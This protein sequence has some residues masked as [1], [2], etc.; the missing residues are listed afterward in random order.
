MY[1]IL[2]VLIIVIINYTGEGFDNNGVPP[3]LSVNRPRP[4]ATWRRN[5]I[6]VKDGDTYV[7]KKQSKH[8]IESLFLLYVTTC[9]VT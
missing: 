4:V 5:R 8:T 2:V 7:V 9:Y 1:I 6:W 3:Q